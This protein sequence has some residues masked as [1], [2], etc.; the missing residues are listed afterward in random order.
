MGKIEDYVFRYS[1]TVVIVFGI[2]GNILVI[3]SILRQKN[4][5][6]KNNYYFLVLHLAICDLAVLILRLFPTVESYWLQEPHSVYY[7]AID[8][9][10]VAIAEA[11]QLAGIGMMFIIS[12][13]RYRGTVHPLKPAI[14][15]QKLKVFCGLMYFAGLVAACGT[16][17]PVC[18]IKSAVVRVAYGK[19]YYAS[20]ILFVYFGPT[21]FMAVVY[22][23]I[24]RALIKQNK[25]MKRICSGVIIQRA[26]D[27]FNILRYIRNRRTYLVCLNTVLFY[28]IGSIPASTWCMS[29][30]AIGQQYEWLWP[31]SDILQIAGSHSINPLIYGILDKKLLTFWKCF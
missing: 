15:R 24:G 1:V 27:S 16:R 14:S 26:P 31:L 13:L 4:N 12:L 30:I 10:V 19:F 25:H 3:L 8:C 6:L 20:S 9:Y 22:Y 23:K 5:V 21:I 7:A 18:F 2:L 28:G 29:A 17:L 11:F